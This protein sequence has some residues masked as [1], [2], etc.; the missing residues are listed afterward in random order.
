ML[1]CTESL[2]LHL[3]FHTQYHVQVFGLVGCCLV[4]YSVLVEA[5]IISI[6]DIITRMVSIQIFVHTS[7]DKVSIQFFNE[8]ELT[9][10]I[11]HRTSLALFINKV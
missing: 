7:I 3:E 5:W 4:P 6:L 10:Q 9:L 1:L 11:Y 2:T 8:I